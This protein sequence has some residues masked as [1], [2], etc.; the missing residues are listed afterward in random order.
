MS[1]YRSTWRFISAILHYDFCPWANRWLAHLKHPVANLT[2]AA[3]AALACGLFV[4]PIALIAFVV[5]SAIMSLGWCWP[6]ISMRG[7]SCT[8][9]FHEARV[10]EGDS[11]R[12]IA[13]IT[14]H[15]PWP[16][17]GLVI[18]PGF[19]WEGETDR[20]SVALGVVAGWSTQ[21][22]EWE[23][24]VPGRGAYP[25]STPTICTSFPFGLR[26]ARKPISVAESLIAWPRLIPLETLLDAAETRPTADEFSD[27]RVG[28]H[29]DMVGTRPF[30]NGDSLRRVHWVQTARTGTMIVSERQTATQPAIRIVF[31]SDP[32]L[33][34]DLTASGTMEWSIRIAASVCAAYHRE[35]A[36]VECCFGHETIEM[37]RGISGLR[38]FLDTLARWK[39][40]PTSHAPACPHEHRQA[41][42]QR[43]HH[44][45][46]G[47]FQ[48]TIT[49]DLGLSHRTEHRH[50]HGEQKQVVLRTRCSNEPCEIC[51]T[52]HDSIDRNAIVLDRT[53]E[54]AADFRRK[55][56]HACHAG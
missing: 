42:C 10:T 15:F 9:R 6:F 29:G 12:V 44:R 28:D 35:N 16:A 26:T 7:V 54:I 4:K 14:N 24:M 48:L 2:L 30:R 22:F 25:R 39:P 51:G 13:H 32:R 1:H 17:W 23:S 37:R 52:A 50:V 41:A 49:T 53:A 21:H 20:S 18:E 56:W 38:S 55:W 11:T 46:C 5:L 27:T 8:I 45:N 31:D 36:M 47:V 19:D 3:I 43:I 40:C 34:S 33:H